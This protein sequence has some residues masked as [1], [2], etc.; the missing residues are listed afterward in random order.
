MKQTL[1][2]KLDFNKSRD[3]LISFLDSR[4]DPVMV[5]GTSANN[6]VIT[7]EVLIIN[8]DLDLYFFTWKYSRKTEQIKI[9]NNVSLCKDKIEIEGKAEIL[10]L[11]TMKENERILEMI[12]KIHPDSI[13]RW[14]SRPNMILIQIKPVF[15]CI[16][17]YIENDYSYLEY[18][19]LMKKE[20][21]RLKWADY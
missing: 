12:R 1:K 9:N 14:K 3:K 20:S 17:G 11:L 5:L 21:Y 8:N 19:N 6:R 10:G 4:D 13:D 18:I 7:R 16:D 2:E 15:A